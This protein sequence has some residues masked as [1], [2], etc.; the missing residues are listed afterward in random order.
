M[1]TTH[2]EKVELTRAHVRSI[3]LRTKKQFKDA[4]LPIIV[5]N[6]FNGDK[7]GAFLQISNAT[8]ERYADSMALMLC[9]AFEFESPDY[10]IIE[11]YIRFFGMFAVDKISGYDCWVF[12]FHVFHQK[13]L[14]TF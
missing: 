4:G 2:S 8:L 11:T 5:H 9:Q 14:C 12:T 1:E 3:F 13:L 6:F 10:E 7:G